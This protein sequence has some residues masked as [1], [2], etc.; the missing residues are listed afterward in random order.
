MDLIKFIRTAPP[1]NYVIS[2]PTA[3]QAPSYHRSILSEYFMNIWDSRI[4]PWPA[5]PQLSDLENLAGPPDKKTKNSIMV[6]MYEWN[7][8]TLVETELQSIELLREYTAIY[9]TGL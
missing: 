7:F 2:P 9:S 1:A 4:P 5:T 8:P 6:P 3:G